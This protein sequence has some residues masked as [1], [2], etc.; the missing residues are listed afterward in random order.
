MLNGV[1]LRTEYHKK[2]NSESHK[3]QV[4]WN[5]GLKIE[6]PKYLKKYSQK[7]FC[8]NTKKTHIK[9]GQH[10]SR[11]TEF[12][13]GIHP[14]TEFKKNHIPWNKGKKYFQISNK[15]HWAWKGG[16][17]PENEKIRKSIEWKLWR[18]QV[19]NRDNFVCWVCN[20]KGYKLHPHHLLK[21]SD[22]PG[23]RFEVNNGLT[24]CKFCHKTYTKFN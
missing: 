2:I 5:K 22:Y 12:K 8:N 11:E 13:K 10:L 3:G 24:L 18:E 6:Q 15:N 1:Y 21:F 7:G 16:I 20:Q 9:K 4:P 17:T 23:L 14:K 19:F